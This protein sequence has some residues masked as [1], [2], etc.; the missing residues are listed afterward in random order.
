MAKCVAQWCML[1]SSEN[2]HRYFIIHMLVT[3]GE[4]KMNAICSN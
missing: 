3:V 2:I 4:P 1:V